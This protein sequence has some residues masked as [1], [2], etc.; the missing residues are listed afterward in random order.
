VT[1]GWQPVR[2]AAARA[3]DVDGGGVA[4]AVYERGRLV[5]DV[6]AGDLADDALV[7]TWSAIKPVT[8]AC[9]LLLAER[10]RIGLDD[11]CGDVWPELGG[12]LVRHVL[13]HA[14]GRASVPPPGTAA[15]LLDWDRAVAALGAAPVD[16]EPGTAVGEHAQTYGHLVG[17]LV[18]RLDGRAPG[19][20]LAEELT[21]PLGLDVHVGVPRSELGRVADTVN[22]TAAWWDGRRGPPGTLRRR[23]LA[24]GVDGALVNSDAWRTGQVPAVNGHATARGL[25]GFWAAFLGGRLPAGVGEVGAAGPDLVLGEDV[26][27]TLAGGRAFDHDIGMGGMGGQVGAAIPAADVAWAFLS[28][29]MGEW[30]RTDAVEQAVLR[31]SGR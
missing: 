2:D 15:S 18:R 7:H 19:T 17:E 27:W 11:D 28:T 10:G 20:F 1:D 3:A 9:L 29:S 22:L 6:V 16:W 4:V 12:T 5:V 14:A 31:C 8:G 25:A 24:D 26:A 30:S 21:G 13:T 23:A